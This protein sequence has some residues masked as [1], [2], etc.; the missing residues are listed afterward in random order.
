M[1]LRYTSPFKLAI[2]Y[3][4]GDGSGWGVGEGSVEGQ[5]LSGTA[6][7][8]NHP[9]RRGDGAML[10]NARGVI[11]ADDGEEILFELSGR[12]V[13]VE[14]EGTARGAQLLMTLFESQAEDYKWLNNTVCISEGQIDPNTLVLHL[15]VFSC[16]NELV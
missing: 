16:E 10:P 15:R 12:T 4:G 14:R 11:T 7:W 13:W 2:P 6:Q 5:R 3:G 8:S 9:Q 1:D